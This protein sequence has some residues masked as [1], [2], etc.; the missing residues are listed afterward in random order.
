M[1][2][3]EV[4]FVE[5]AWLAGGLGTGGKPSFRVWRTARGRTGG[6]TCGPAGDQVDDQYGGLSGS[7]HRGQADVQACGLF[8]ELGERR[9]H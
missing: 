9:A 3:M 7:Q 5:P 8:A 1:I 4:I 2:P 6:W